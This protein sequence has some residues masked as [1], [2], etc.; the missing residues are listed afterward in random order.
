MD[1]APWRCW[2]FSKANSS[3]ILL[4]RSLLFGLEEKG[5][6]GRTSIG[7]A[8]WARIS[9]VQGSSQGSIDPIWDHVE[10][11]QYGVKRERDLK[12]I[13]RENAEITLSRILIKVNIGTWLRRTWSF[14]LSRGLN[15]CTLTGPIDLPHTIRCTH[16][17]DN[18]M[19]RDRDAV[20]E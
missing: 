3:A 17:N 6:N 5:G 16:G 19:L 9:S 7:G 18:D 12:P 11:I 14:M 1:G 15:Y 8:I 20:E 2:L 13:W 4:G 10:I